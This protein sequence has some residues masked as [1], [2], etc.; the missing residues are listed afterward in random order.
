MNDFLSDDYVPFKSAQWQWWNVFGK[1][2]GAEYVNKDKYYFMLTDFMPYHV[3]WVGYNERLRK[4]APTPNRNRSDYDPFYGGPPYGAAPAG[5]DPSTTAVFPV[6]CVKNFDKCR[7][8][9]FA[10]N[11]S[12]DNHDKYDYFALAKRV[13]GF[14]SVIIDLSPTRFERISRNYLTSQ[15]QMDQNAYLRTD[16]EGMFLLSGEKYRNDFNT[17]PSFRPISHQYQSTVNQSMVNQQLGR[18]ARRGRSRNQPRQAQ[19]SSSKSSPLFLNTVD[20]NH[21]QFIW[22]LQKEENWVKDSVNYAL[23]EAGDEA[24]AIIQRLESISLPDELDFDDVL[25]TRYENIMC[26]PKMVES[27]GRIRRRDDPEPTN[28]DRFKALEI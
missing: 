14:V 7:I 2:M 22:N 9:E 27:F 21:V 13:P 11:N 16:A 10:V 5:V 6:P 26:Y 19:P 24:E 15:D 4:F 1:T 20:P 3:H 12:I 17:N 25:L 28:F 8:C 18:S 23:G